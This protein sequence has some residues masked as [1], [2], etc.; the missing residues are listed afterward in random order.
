MFKFI[1]RFFPKKSSVKNFS[2]TMTAATEGVTAQ[3]HFSPE[4]KEI[5]KRLKKNE[6]INNE[7]LN[8]VI[9]FYFNLPSIE[10]GVYNINQSLTNGMCF[11]ISNVN[12]VYNEQGDIENIFLNLKEIT[13][14]IEMVVTISAKDFH[15]TFNRLNFQP[16][17]S[18][19]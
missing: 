4:I 16:V 17:E 6:T 3:R 14:N 7:D 11:E 19:G 18:K 2:T 9:G 5:L 8:K 15:E 13:F 12:T 1:R 10:P